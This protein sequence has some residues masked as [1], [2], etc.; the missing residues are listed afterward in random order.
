MDPVMSRLSAGA[1]R[2]AAALVN[3]LEPRPADQ[4]DFD[5]W[6]V[7]EHIPER[8][9]I[10]GFLNARRYVAS[11]DGPR[12]GSCLT[13]YELDAVSAFS[14]PAYLARLNAPSG[15]TASM[16]SKIASNRRVVCAVVESDG[17]ARSKE[18]LVAERME[19]QCD[20]DDV[21]STAI[22]D[23]LR[24][25]SITAGHRLLPD[26]VAGAG[27]AGTR[28]GRLASAVQQP[29]QP[30]QLVLVELSESADRRAVADR[31]VAIGMDVVGTY[32][33]QL[34]MGAQW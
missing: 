1:L 29:A 15:W 16:A 18:V 25:G 27:R 22:R 5:A 7:Q 28:E 6:H 33:L 20:Q 9:G 3:W 34:Q 14:S 17:P 30:G 13:V 10:P 24:E 26:E 32:E 12:Y 8:M 4:A 31:L 2:G 21:E 11:G 23:L 19:R